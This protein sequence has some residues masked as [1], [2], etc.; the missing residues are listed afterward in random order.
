SAGWVLLTGNS[1]TSDGSRPAAAQARSICS[2]TAA[3]FSLIVPTSAT[4]RCSA[5]SGRR[6]RDASGGCP[7]TGPGTQ[8]SGADVGAE[9]A[10]VDR[11]VVA[12]ADERPAAQA[13]LTG[14]TR[15]LQRPLFGVV[16]PV[17]G[18]LDPVGGGVVEQVVDQLPLGRRAEPPAAVFRRAGDADLVPDPDWGAAALRLPG[19]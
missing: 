9:Q 7:S 11:V 6:G 18:R 1:R 16:L 10:V 17:R 4:L 15:L 8:H 2:R 3:R 19:D 5:R 13:A 14:E 12:A